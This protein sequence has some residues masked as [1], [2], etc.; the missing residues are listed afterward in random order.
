MNS[1]KLAISTPWILA[2]TAA[3]APSQIPEDYRGTATDQ[4]RVARQIEEVAEIS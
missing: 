2:A 3:V 1:H 4:C